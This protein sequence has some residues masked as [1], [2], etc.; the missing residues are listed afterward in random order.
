[1]TVRSKPTPIARFV[2]AIRSAVMLRPKPN[3]GSSVSA[4][5]WVHGGC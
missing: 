1:M 5:V 3:P 2:A 4:D